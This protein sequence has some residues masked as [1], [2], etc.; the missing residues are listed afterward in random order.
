VA[1]TAVLPQDKD[2]LL[3]KDLDIMIMI[4]DTPHHQLLQVTM[5]TLL[6]HLEPLHL[7]KVIM[8]TMNVEVAHAA[9]DL[10]DQVDEDHQDHRVVV[11]TLMRD[12][13]VKAKII[14]TEQVVNCND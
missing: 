13:R 1:H 9:P 10:Q 12:L 3:E 6:L 14:G 2:V 7:L 4:V 11:E 8:T 5:I